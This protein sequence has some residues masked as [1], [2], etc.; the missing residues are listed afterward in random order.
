[1]KTQRKKRSYF[2]S[3]QLIISAFSIGEVLF[4]YHL[5]RRKLTHK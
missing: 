4:N 3:S 1:M 2:V 5:E